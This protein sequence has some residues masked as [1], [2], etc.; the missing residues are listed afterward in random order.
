[1]T[2][3]RSTGLAVHRVTQTH[4]SGKRAAQAAFAQL[5]AATAMLSN[6]AMTAP[7]TVR[8]VAAETQHIETATR[9]ATDPRHQQPVIAVPDRPEEMGQTIACR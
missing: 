7:L 6:A 9:H 2:R 4:L 3:P 1:M 8:L 5:C